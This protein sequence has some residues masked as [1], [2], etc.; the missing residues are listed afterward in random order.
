[1]HGIDKIEQA[2]SADAALRSQLVA[3]REAVFTRAVS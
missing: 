2:L 3:I 1:M